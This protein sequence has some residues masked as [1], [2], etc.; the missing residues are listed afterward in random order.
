MHTHTHTWTDA[1]RL[2]VFISIINSEKMIS[3]LETP[4]K[5]YLPPHAL[6]SHYL[7]MHL[8]YSFKC[9][10]WTPSS[11]S[12]KSSFAQ[13]NTNKPVWLGM[14]HQSW[15]WAR[16]LHC[17]LAHSPP[18]GQ[19]RSTVRP[20]PFTIKTDWNKSNETRQA[21]LERVESWNER[22]QV[23]LIGTGYWYCQLRL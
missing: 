1:D 11:A 7:Y 23:D 21:S 4:S 22:F 10:S 15:I 20:E 18:H 12:C 13:S 2:H 6:Y 9:F 14:W 17:L 19:R 8:Y 16:L 3:C 5:N